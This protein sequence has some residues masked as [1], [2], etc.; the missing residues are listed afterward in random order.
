VL[1]FDWIVLNFSLELIY[2]SHIL[3]GE[4]PFLD[5]GDRDK[6]IGDL[7]V[8]ALLMDAYHAC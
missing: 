6:D 7:A 4:L 2:S 1:G 8:T 3:G 5:M